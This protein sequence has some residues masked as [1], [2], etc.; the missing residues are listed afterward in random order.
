MLCEVLAKLVAVL[1]QHWLLLTVGPWLDGRAATRKVRRLRRLL[2]ELVA[3]LGE[4]RRWRPC[5]AGSGGIAS[6]SSSQPA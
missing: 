1:V 4:A 3:A 2:T 6:P 5:C